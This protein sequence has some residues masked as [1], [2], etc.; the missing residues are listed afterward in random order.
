MQ[1]KQN[2]RHAQRLRSWWAVGQKALGAIA[3]AAMLLSISG[4]HAS[5]KTI[6]R[7]GTTQPIDS[8]NPFVSQSDYSSAT[9][10][11]VYPHL[12]EYNG[13][14]QIV[15]SFAVKW[16][17]S[18]DGLTWTFHTAPGAQWSDG[19]PL[20]AKDAAF[21][22]NMIVKFQSGPTGQLAGWVAHM[23]KAEASD[24]NTLV[25]SYDKPVANVLTQIQALHILPEHVWAPL[26]GGDGS[27]ISSFENE[28]PIVS[29]GPFIL[30]KHE[31][32]QLALFTRN[33]KWWG[34]AQPKIDGF[35][36]QFFANDDA[37]V[38]ALTTDQID[39]IGEQTPP[40]AVDTL[41]KAGEVVLAGPGVGLKTFIINTNPDKPRHREL[42]DPN[43][44]E[45]MEYAIDRDT[46][47]KTVWLGFATPGST[48]VSP[49]S[50]Y[51][52]DSIQ[53]LPYDIE[54]ANALLD[55]AG[56]KKGADGIRVANGEPMDYE[57]VFPTEEN[58]TGDRTFQLI[59][60]GF[61]KIGINITQRKM[62]PDAATEAIEAPDGK[63][64][65]YD[66]AM[67]NWVPPVEPDFLL[68]VM[69]CDQ[70]GNNSDSGYCNAEY[71]A[72]YQKQGTLLDDQQRRAEI[73]KMQKW[74]F[75]ARPYIVL[76][77]PNVI[78]AHSPKWDGFVL[79]P[80]MG[81]VNNLSTETLLTVH[82]K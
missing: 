1:M 18:A 80:L 75:D 16:E 70:R 47:V 23:T 9:Y 46:I 73:N 32:D 64:E 12:T 79:S 29:G 36:F 21:T 33:P 52:D 6:L 15:P 34:S 26:T 40:T 8:L 28:A 61:K 7:I 5:A 20:T 3:L 58:G 50:G 13:K 69:T 48:I 27:A 63:F 74:L 17:T 19:K 11:Y 39:M 71:D 72:M 2:E 67:W 49:A 4:G 44:R 81:S 14:L 22:L 76:N 62:D 78:E 77:Y 25:V 45:A 42:L 30:V 35:G 60:A 56:L 65:D 82:P 68:S 38:K 51:H 37:M 57:V 53:P 43:V 54:K 24:D 41:K 59:K 66:L 31:K 55:A 10:Q